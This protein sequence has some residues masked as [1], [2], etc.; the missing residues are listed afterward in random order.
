VAP[1]PVPYLPWLYSAKEKRKEK[2]KKEK[3]KSETW[4]SCAAHLL[5]MVL[6]LL[7]SLP[8]V[9]L[10]HMQEEEQADTVINIM[11]SI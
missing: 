8:D 10:P 2:R 5:L 6:S 1:S 11:Y 7:F 3:M 9:Y 4:E